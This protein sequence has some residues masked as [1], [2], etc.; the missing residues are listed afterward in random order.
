MINKV[1]SLASKYFLLFFLLQLFMSIVGGAAI[2]LLMGNRLLEEKNSHMENLTR[3]L[4]FSSAPLIF[5]NDIKSLEEIVKEMVERDS[6]KEIVRI[7][8]E[9]A[10]R[11]VLAKYNRPG[12][13]EHL[14]TITVPIKLKEISLGKVWFTYSLSQAR[15]NIYKATFFLVLTFIIASTFAASLL[16]IFTQKVV[17]TPLKA[18]ALEAEKITQGSSLTTNLDRKDEIGDIMKALNKASTILKEKEEEVLKSYEQLK[19]RCEEVR[20]A[21]DKL[22]EVDKMKS[23]FLAIVSHELRT[24]LTIIRGNLEMLEK[25]A[26]LNSS[27]KRKLK[28]ILKRVD[29][30]IDLVN[31]LTDISLMEKGEIQEYFRKEKIYLPEILE[32]TFDEFSYDLTRKK[33]S[34]KKIIEPSLPSLNADPIRLRQVLNNLFSN[35]LKFTPSQG[36]ILVEVK[37]TNGKLLISF[38]NTGPPIP[39]KELENIF[40]PFYR[41]GSVDKGKGLGL[42]LA[43]S[44]AIIEAHG[45]EMWAE[46]DKRKTTFYISLPSSQKG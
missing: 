14:K 8:I 25:D 23:Q 4:S 26:Q 19:K 42:G 11:V 29:Y 34:F 27:S 17:A 6:A 16:L 39:K 1:S 35:S 12:N 40:L 36:E 24:P 15:Q 18:V 33:I 31:E 44:K 43:I 7:E 9:S 2:A 37:K 21:K 45:G 28:T 46:S 32:E 10:D 20:K 30:L 22:S 13:F 3:S 5:I 38:S 41:V